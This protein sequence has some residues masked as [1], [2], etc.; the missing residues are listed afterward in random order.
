MSRTFAGLRTYF[1][2]LRGGP[3]LPYEGGPP[4]ATSGPA[5]YPIYGRPKHDETFDSGSGWN[6]PALPIVWAYPGDLEHDESFDSGGEIWISDAVTP[7]TAP[8][9]GFTLTVPGPWTENQGGWAGAFNNGSYSFVATYAGPAFPSPEIDV[10]LSTSPPAVSTALHLAI[11]DIGSFPTPPV[12]D[13]DMFTVVATRT[14]G[15]SV[16]SALSFT[17]SFII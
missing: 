12:T 8:G 13:G 7:F 4:H 17:I 2:G 15:S 10:S 3:G 1:T 9:V 16:Q 5:E 14:I 11:S 6:V